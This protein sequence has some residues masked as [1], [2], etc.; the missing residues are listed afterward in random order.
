MSISNEIK[1][2]EIEVLRDQSRVEKIRQYIADHLATDLS[3]A[4]VAQTFGLSISS[5]QHIFKRY[6][7]QTYQH[8]LEETRMT[9]A[10][11]LI[12][13]EDKRINE[14]M[15]ATGYNNRVTFNIAF[16]KRFK[17]SPRHFKR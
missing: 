10:F 17:H 12:T 1:N 14:A 11:E 6:Q 15:Y 4:T 13:Q 9:K 2:K 7:Q 16:K 5:L 8:Y 3:A